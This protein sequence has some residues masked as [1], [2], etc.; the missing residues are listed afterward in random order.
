MMPVEKLAEF[1]AFILELVHP[2][3]GKFGA[4]T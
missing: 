1:V 2:F 3:N 4:L